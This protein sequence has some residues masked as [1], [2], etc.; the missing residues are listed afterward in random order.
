MSA[1]YQ[2]TPRIPSAPHSTPFSASSHMNSKTS[3]LRP[4]VH[5]PFDKFTQPEFDAWIG[6]ITGALKRALGQDDEELDSNDHSLNKSRNLIRSRPE[7]QHYRDVDDD[8]LYDET[9][10]DSFAEIKARRAAGKGKARDPREGPGLGKGNSMQPIEIVSS[11]E[12]DAE[13]AAEVELSVAVLED[14]DEDQSPGEQ[15]EGEHY[16]EPYSGDMGQPSSR[17][18]QSID[19]SSR[20]ND[21]ATEEEEYVSEDEEY[22]EGLD[23]EEGA[24]YEEFDDD[25]E[26]D[27]E[28]ESEPPRPAKAVVDEIIEIDSDSD[29][30]V[31]DEELSEE[32]QPS[33]LHKTR[34]KPL[35][36]EE[37]EEGEEGSGGY[38][39]YDEE[40]EQAL[41]R[42]E[43]PGTSQLYLRQQIRHSPD[44]QYEDD[45]GDDVVDADAEADEEEDDEIQEIQPP[46][47]D[48]SFPPKS[49]TNPDQDRHIELPDRWEGPRTYAEDY[50]SG[51][52]IRIPTGAKLD[53]HHLGPLD[54]ETEANIRREASIDSSMEQRNED[55][56]SFPP[57]DIRLE[58][59]VDIVDPWES[60]RIYAQ[61]F[62]AG[63]S[64]HLPRGTHTSAHYMGPMD[65]DYVEQLKSNTAP[66]HPSEETQPPSDNTSFPDGNTNEDIPVEIQDPWT[67][68]QTYAEDYYS[69]GEVRAT[70]GVPVDPAL[71]SGTHGVED[72]IDNFLTPGALTPSQGPSEENTE[73]VYD[74]EVDVREDRD[75]GTILP[76]S[77]NLFVPPSQSRPIPTD[78]EVIAVDDS[79]NE[80]DHSLSPANQEHAAV[81]S[82]YNFRHSPVHEGPHKQGQACEEASHELDELNE[83]IPMALSNSYDSKEP[84]ASASDRNFEAE[85]GESQLQPS[86]IKPDIFHEQSDNNVTLEG[87]R[88]LNPRPLGADNVDSKRRSHELMATESA[89]RMEMTDSTSKDPPAEVDSIRHKTQV[90]SETPQEREG[91]GHTEA[92]TDPSGVDEV[93]TEGDFGADSDIDSMLRAH[94]PST[95][96]ITD[97]QR[98]LATVG[99]IEGNDE[100][101]RS[102]PG[103][104]DM[105]DSS[106][107]AIPITSELDFPDTQPLA[108]FSEIEGESIPVDDQVEIESSHDFIPSLSS[109]KVFEPLQ[110]EGTA[111][112]SKESISSVP[113]SQGN[114]ATPL[115]A[116]VDADG[117]VDDGYG[118]DDIDV[119]STMSEGKSISKEIFI[120]D[121]AKTEGRLSVEPTD[122]GMN[123]DVVSIASQEDIDG[124]NDVEANS[125]GSEGTSPVA[126][127]PTLHVEN[128]TAISTS[129][130]GVQSS[131]L[132][133]IPT[134]TDPSVPNS[135][136]PNVDFSQHSEA[137]SMTTR[138]A[139]N[140]EFA[141]D[142]KVVT[143]VDA[144]ILN[145]TNHTI[146]YPK[147]I[148]VGGQNIES[149]IFTISPTLQQEPATAPSVSSDAGAPADEASSPAPSDIVSEAATP[150]SIPHRAPSVSMKMTLA[151]KATDPILMAD[152]YPYCLS[153]PGPSTYHLN[154]DDGAEVAFQ[155]PPEPETLLEQQINRQLTNI[156][157]DT[158]LTSLSSAFVTEGS[159]TKRKR[160]ISPE[161]LQKSGA[162][163]RPQKAKGRKGPKPDRKGKGHAI[164][165]VMPEPNNEE[166]IVVK[167]RQS[168]KNREPNRAASVVSIQ[169]SQ[170]SSGASA[171]YK[172]LQPNSRSSSVSSIVQES[173]SLI[174]Q[175]SPT[176]TKPNI[177]YPAPVVNLDTLFH[178]HGQK[179]KT[180]ALAALHSSSPRSQPKRP[181]PSRLP[182]SSTMPDVQSPTISTPTPTAISPPLPPVNLDVPAVKSETPDTAKTSISVKTETSSAKADSPTKTTTTPLRSNFSTPVTRSHCRYHRISLP[183][184]EGGT[185]INFLV[186]GCSL[187]DRELMEEE[188]IV[189][190][191]DATVDDSRNMLKDIENLGFSLDLIG[192][193]RQLVGLDILREQEVFYLPHPGEVV[194]WKKPLL[195]KTA[196]EKAAMVRAPGEGSSQAGSPGGYSGPGIIVPLSKRHSVSRSSF[197]STPSLDS[198]YLRRSAPSSKADHSDEEEPAAKRTRSSPDESSEVGAPES[199]SKN[200]TLKS[201]RSKR[202]DLNYEP[203]ED[204]PEESDGEIVSSRKRRK[205]ARGVKRSRVSEVLPTG[206]Q[207][208]EREVKKL[209]SDATN[210][211]D[212]E[213]QSASVDI[214]TTERS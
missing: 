61:D 45:E 127:V 193:I 176:A 135:L 175:P 44:T 128:T 18:L 107:S 67:G 105:G 144:D 74:D 109:R 185:R 142:A 131:Q 88:Q 121:E 165:V 178:A 130:S 63:G 145:S 208:E 77:T 195:N 6:G 188:E 182:S 103:L 115:G 214:P 167:P 92:E 212:T 95:A 207:D 160:T 19:Q 203:A 4:P 181:Q 40:E 112:M 174:N 149:S 2:F 129:E 10:D 86:K 210:P 47:N 71:L 73:G 180:L 186:P 16:E 153:T 8:A 156:G 184:E 78:A 54:G 11:D 27:N 33:S 32:D 52:D 99:N 140:D 66:K 137:T 119:Q 113:L 146:A 158:S 48:T 7:L 96:T 194:T 98:H 41:E 162:S 159:I 168:A 70:P 57:H 81:G 89:P 80:E 133:S 53:A 200:R 205:P 55:D 35:E 106:T 209:K 1:P 196:S 75:E 154:E 87:H 138:T 38:D 91:A 172:L 34:K 171:T 179:K 43:R 5:N 76:P 148:S 97:M 125:V 157:Q 152:P 163:P 120:V 3:V 110:T 17:Y 213:S 20:A 83:D 14:S 187:N 84:E 117:E 197:S 82:F 37:E 199:Q 28:E 111:E 60:S 166:T 26:Y 100:D 173:R 190:H 123:I 198:N 206:V 150:S 93:A 211:A 202:V 51:G 143:A 25:E 102:T 139:I 85:T 15:E 24:E 126:E 191:G 29:G 104:E 68:P 101:I 36:D 21:V 155:Y 201:R 72:D 161:P 23:H 183:R 169:E 58:R 108:Q 116:D 46:Q 90:D 164:K 132:S 49:F 189:D 151:R 124:H 114:N 192:I 170:I 30:E 50:Y 64:I 134:L 147:N 65:V 59:P 13:E 22:E 136:H 42:E 118:L 122:F 141:S 79:D 9:M 39:E 204:E 177:F 94:E 69:G 12:E 56:T 31:D 62:Y